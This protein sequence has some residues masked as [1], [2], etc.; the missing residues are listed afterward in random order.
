[1][2]LANAAILLLIVGTTTWLLLRTD[3]DALLPVA[4]VSPPPARAT[5]DVYTSP[6]LIAEVERSMTRD[7]LYR[8]GALTIGALA[9]KLG[10]LEYKLRR[11][12][13]QGLGY[14]NFNAFLNH[15]RVEHAKA[16]LAERR[17]A[18]T[19]VLNVAMDCGFQS[20]GPF[21]RAFKSQT[22]MTPTEFRRVRPVHFNIG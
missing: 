15:Y 11:I 13:N 18:D 20:L 7:R 5:D 2:S 22:G 14:R 9:A 17:N 1:L 10:L 3:I 12:I 21:N 8:D 4:E 16:V 6:S 19:S